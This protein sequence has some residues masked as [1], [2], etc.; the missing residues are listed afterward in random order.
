MKNKIYKILGVALVAMLLASLTVGLAAPAAAD[1]G[2]LKWSKMSF[3]PQGFNGSY[4]VDTNI[5]SVGPIAKAIDG[6]L[7]A[8]VAGLADIFKS[9]DGGRTWKE[10]KYAAAG[11][12][13]VVA[14]TPSSKDASIVYVAEV[15]AGVSK[16]WKSTDVFT[17][18]KWSDIATPSLTTLLV[19][20]ENI[21]S[22]DVGYKSGNPFVFVG[23]STG[24]WAGD[25]CYIN[26]AA[27]GA[28]WQRL[29]LNVGLGT[30]DVYAVAVDPGFD[31]NSQ[32]EVVCT[33]GFDTWVTNNAGS[34]GAWFDTVALK[35]G[36]PPLPAG[37]SFDIVG[38]AKICFP[39]DF[40]ASTNYDLYVGVVANA[41]TVLGAGD[42]YEVIPGIAYDCN[43]AA[44]DTSGFV[45]DGIISLD[46]VGN[47]GSTTMLAGQ[48]TAADVYY[49]T[50]GG[51]SW[52]AA[53]GGGNKAP[54]GNGPTYVV[55]SDDFA[56]SN[57]AWA[58]T[59]TVVGDS[60]AAFSL[61]TDGGAT[62]NGISLIDTDIA[63]VNDIT[64]ASSN[65]RFMAASSS[66]APA[67]T[68]DTLWKYDG[69]NWELV[70][71]EAAIDLT[72]VSPKYATDT[73]VF[74]ADSVTATI[75]KSTNGGASFR[76][77]VNAPLGVPINGWVV[78]SPTLLLSSDA[79][80]IY[81]TKDAGRTA[82][83]TVGA[84]IVAIS[85]AMSPAYDTDTTLLAGSSGPFIYKS[86]NAG[87]TWSTIDSTFPSGAT[88]VYVA[89]DPLYATNSTFYAAS[90]VGAAL[91]VER[92]D[93]TNKWA[94]ITPTWPATTGGAT[95]IACS[96][97]GTLYVTDS[98]ADDMFRTLAPTAPSA[99]K[100]EWE[101]VTLNV[102]SG[103]PLASLALTSGSN[104]LWGIDGTTGDAV[105]TYEDTLA[106][107]VVLLSPADKA[108][109][110][111]TGTASL[112]WT[113]LTGADKYEFLCNTRAD[114]YGVAQTVTSPASVNAG[115]VSGLSG[116]ATYYWKVRVLA[117]NPIKSRWSTVWSFTTG[118]VEAQ[119]NP[120]TGPVSAAPAPGATGVPLRPTFAWN[121]SDFATAYEL[122]LSKAP[123]TTAGG[124][125]V[126]A[127]I[128]LTG[129]NALVNTSWQCDRDLDYSTT[130][131]WHVRSINAT[132]QSQWATGVFTTMEKPVPPAPPVQVNIPAT[133]A[134]ITPAW[135]WAIVIIGAI[136]V[137]AVIVLIVTTRR[138]P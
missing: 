80:N 56:T 67:A 89:F 120:F 34:F 132:S 111:R 13:A 21:T 69:T 94:S 44:L 60:P 106:V 96:A 116:G 19:F 17:K 119:W 131:Y 47:A 76:A 39:D 49:S 11:G 54:S 90:T 99:A 91:D 127:L 135:I 114:F 59:A 124:F 123:G 30:D 2:V 26:E 36:S 100:C 52:K 136:L 29:G 27:Y 103:T 129:T 65:L 55:M 108:T 93:P 137:I 22:L 23:T 18:T 7:L 81:K 14:I 101:Q 121:A 79:T 110:G 98:A 33:D 24:A 105:W 43:A 130:Y 68:N 57:K 86:T 16:V 1:P 25:V 112:G 77:L 122:E 125:F 8:W 4:F 61:T 133:P 58:A 126:D 3:P 128:G 83:S 70:K 31:A 88:N 53:S 109:S 92:Y 20:G 115:S 35:A 15:V 78:V 63:A 95:G 66:G 107:S 118:M 138:V 75:Y 71:N 74:C 28:G 46:L 32:I 5:T 73:T 62:W 97:D 48:Y 41:G 72:Q 117:G 12:G 87:D 40:D 134:P 45:A 37:V 85:F 82:W 84:G 51:S 50:D 10:T 102:S 38:A 113:A 42:V 9:T 104:V 64:F 6:S